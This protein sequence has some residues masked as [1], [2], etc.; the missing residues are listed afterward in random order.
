MRSCTAMKSGKRVNEVHRRRETFGIL[1]MSHIEKIAARLFVT[2][3]E[4]IKI[5]RIVAKALDGQRYPYP[6]LVG[7]AW[8][9]RESRAAAPKRLMTYA[10]THMGNFLLLLLLGLGLMAGI[11]TSRLRFWPLGLD[12]GLKARIW[13]SSLGFGPQD[14]NLG[15]GTGIWGGG[16]EEEEEEK[17]I[18]PHMCK[19]IGHRPLPCFPLNFKHNLLRQGTGTADHLMLSRLFIPLLS[20]VI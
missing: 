15:L 9:W 10:F 16:A 8:R 18:I 20:I 19:S 11:W 1:R 13:A 17:E 5:K 4:R 6:A 12:L 14:W 7:C 3:R 2:C